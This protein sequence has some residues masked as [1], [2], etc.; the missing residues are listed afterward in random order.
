[1]NHALSGERAYE[2]EVAEAIAK[3]L[4]IPPRAPIGMEVYGNAP[5]EG[6]EAVREFGTG[7]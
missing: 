7:R 3:G 1:M 2:K 6:R 4:P 5:L